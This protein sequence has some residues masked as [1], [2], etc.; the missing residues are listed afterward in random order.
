M[1]TEK[2]NWLKK[3]KSRIVDITQQSIINSVISSLPLSEDRLRKY[4][5]DKNVPAEFINFIVQQIN[6]SRKN[7]TETIKEEVKKYISAIDISSEI[8]RILSK[9]VIE[10]KTEI[11]LVPSDKNHYKSSVKSTVNLRFDEREDL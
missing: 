9:M 10:I 6:T 8:Q 11:R 2:R 3:A 5:L 1:K 4:L 7:I